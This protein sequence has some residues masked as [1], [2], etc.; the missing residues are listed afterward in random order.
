MT[1]IKYTEQQE[2]VVNYSGETLVVKSG[3]GS[4]KTSV[5]KG[6]ARANPDKR[7]LYICCN[8]PIQLEAEA[9]FPKNV[10]CRTGHAIAY[11][12]RGKAL[13]HKLTGNL[14]M[15]DVKQY[16]QI[17]KWELVSDTIRVFNNFLVSADTEITH[18]NAI[19]LK[20]T[21]TK[22]KQWASMAV[23]NA[24]KMW[25][26]SIDPNNR[27]PCVHDVYMKLYC[28]GQPELHT[29]FSVILLD[30]AQDS[31]P[32]LSDFVARQQCRKIIVGDDHQQLYRFRGADNAMQKFIDHYHADVAKITQS[33]RFGPKIA[34][35]ASRILRYK[36]EQV[37]SEDFPITGNGSIND[38]IHHNLPAKLAKEQ[39]TKLHRTVT[40][41][42]KTAFDNQDRKVF[43]IGG[44]DNYNV[45]EV[46]DVYHLSINA[47][48]KVKRK[49]LLT[50]FDSYYLYE[51]VAK[52]SGDI[53]MR[54]IVQ[55]IEQQGGKLPRGIEL[56]RRNECKVEEKA[57]IIIGTAHRSK[58]LEWDTVRLAGDFPDLMDPELDLTSE[59]LADELNLLYVACTR[60]IENLEPGP[61]V[62]A[63]LN[64][65]K[66]SDKEKKNAPDDETKT[67]TQTKKQIM[68]PEPS[69]R[70]PQR[71]LLGE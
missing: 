16:L 23:Q 58:G 36:S 37:G 59:E 8:K 45:Q 67:K 46:L 42:L 50:E 35:V 55:L 3:A 71:V 21:T 68:R 65:L 14:R 22:Q 18:K 5:L 43:W 70:P 6:F 66:I 38:T 44:L 31:N 52:D 53:E 49:K 48:D 40:G 30:E 27:F 57:D 1:G 56:L 4:G 7:M 12:R 39:H 62:Q 28:L 61:T 63:I 15:T 17:N 54:R 41:T 34:E 2:T 47:R 29:W 9:S 11:A 51:S 26:A 19:G 33:F 64:K 60:A 20:T 13:K 69:N 32:V 24:K 25:Q 10:H